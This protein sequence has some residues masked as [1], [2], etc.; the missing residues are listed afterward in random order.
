MYKIAF[1]GSG[2]WGIAVAMVAYN[3]KHTVKMWSKIPEEID[4]INRTRENSRCL[5]NV[6]IPEGIEFTTN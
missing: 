1:L 3:N 2:A 6:K 4:E 5:K